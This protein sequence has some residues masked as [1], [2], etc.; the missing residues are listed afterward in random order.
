M[1]ARTPVWSLALGLVGALGGSAS[2]AQ[3]QL[4]VPAMLEERD[5]D[6]DGLLQRTEAPI[7]LLPHFEEID[8]DG[9]GGIDSFE[10]WEYDRHRR[11]QTEV[12]PPAPQRPAASPDPSPPKTMVE[13]VKV[14][15]RD[16]ADRLSLDEV[17]AE[18]H[19]A[20]RRVDVDAD[21]FID[22]DEARLMD[23]R[24][25]RSARSP[26]SEPQPRPQS[27]GRS[28]VR[29]VGFMD[30]NGDGRLQ[31]KEAPLRVQYLFEQIDLDGDGAI[32][33]REAEAADAAG[34]GR[35]PDGSGR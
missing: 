29:T 17:P 30:T 6:G 13:A 1:R 2:S 11:E 32:D 26:Q 33:V 14:G 4:N 8:R 5:A 23:E 25:A 12:A 27:S 19:E 34:I 16:G 31:K 15:D 3:Q 10:A 18:Q 35:E 20:F 28:F 7:A 24:L 21:G 9:D 22:L